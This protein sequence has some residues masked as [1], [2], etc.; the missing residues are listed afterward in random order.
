MSAAWLLNLTSSFEPT[1]SLRFADLMNEVS[2]FLNFGNDYTALD[3]ANSA[4]V[5]VNVQD[6]VARFYNEH[7]WSFLEPTTTLTTVS[8]TGDY[9][10][11]DEFGGTI[12]GD[13][14]FADDSGRYH[15]IVLRSEGFIS[16]RRQDSTSTGRPTS[17]AV[18][19]KSSTGSAGQRYQIMLDPIPDAVYVLDYVYPAQ[20]NKLTT[21]NPYPLGGMWHSQTIKQACLAA[22][23]AGVDD[24]IGLH[25]GLYRAALVRSIAKDN[26]IRTPST[27]GFNRDGHHHHGR[28][29]NQVGRHNG[30]LSSA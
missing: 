28:V 23:E 18:R 11:P 26:D 10:P 12:Y 8:G 17:C 13:M 25:E 14:T 7:D 24:E 6:G 19:Y 16:K 15:A 5:N 2:Y 21:N 4:R 1:L 30:V 20:K 29:S 22:A 27:M 9:D 3:A